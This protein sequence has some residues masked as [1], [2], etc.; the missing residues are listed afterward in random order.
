MTKRNLRDLSENLK[1][2]IVI[3]I[4][5]LIGKKDMGRIVQGLMAEKVLKLMKDINLQI[6]EG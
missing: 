2:C 5:I 4:G 6:Q 1:S 3:V